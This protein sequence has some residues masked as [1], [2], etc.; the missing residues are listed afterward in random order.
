MPVRNILWFPDI[1]EDDIGIV[2]GKGLNL[3][4]MARADFPIPPGFVVTA[5]AYFDFLD[6]SSLRKKIVQAIDAIDTENTK[7]LEEVSE[8]A[9]DW[10]RQAKMPEELSNEIKKNYLK[11]SEKRIGFLSSSEECFVAV[12]SSATAEDLPEASF[13]GQQETYLNVHGK[14]NV[15]VA[16]QKCWASLF[17][18]RAVYYRKKQNFPTDKVGIAVVIQKMVESTASG[19]MFTADPTGDES[20]IIIEAGFGLG[21]A[22]VSGSVIPDNYVIDKK[23]MAISEKKINFQEWKIIKKGSENIKQDIPQSE[24]RKQKLDDRTILTLAQIGLEIQNYY[25]KPQDIEFAINGKELYIVQS[26]AITTLGLKTKMEGAKERREKMQQ[27]KAKIVLTGLGASPGIISGRVR[28]V[29]DVEDSAK[30]QPG[31]ILVTK[32][33]SPDWVPTMKKSIAIITDE[34][35]KTC[36]AGKTKVLTS[37][38]IIDFEE[39]FN[40]AEQGESFFALSVNRETLKSEWKKINACMKRKAE[41]IKIAVSQTGKANE[42]CVELTPSHKMMHL[43]NRQIVEKE[44]KGILDAEELVCTIDSIPIVSDASENNLKKAYL[45][46]ALFT[47]GSIQLTKR[48]GHITFVQKATPEKKEF[49]ETVLGHFRDLFGTSMNQKERT[50]TSTIRGYTFTSTAMAYNCYQKAPA[51][52]LLESYEAL[53]EWVLRT[54]EENLLMFLAGVIDGDGSFSKSHG[55]RLHI[56][57]SDEKLTKSIVLGCLRLGI[58]PTLQKNRETCLN[59]QIVEGLEKLLKY[60]KRVKFSPR[61][62][63][64]GVKL[65]SAKQLLGDIVNEVNWGGKI[66]PYVEKNLLIDSKKVFERIVPMAKKEAQ[67]ELQKICSSPIRMKRAVH[68]QN[69]GETDVFNIEVDEHHNYVVFTEQFTPLWVANCHAAIVSRELGIPCVVGTEKATKIL[70]D[71]DLVTVDGFDGFIYEGKVELEAPKNLEEQM[72]IIEKNE[73]EPFEKAIKKELKETAKQH[74][75]KERPAAFEKE[76]KIFEI[77]EEEEKETAQ[78]F[79]EKIIEEERKEAEEIVKDFGKEEAEEMPAEKLEEEEEKIVE[80]LEKVSVKV[81]VNVALPEAAASAAKT[82]A[83]GVGLLRAEHMITAAGKHPA[84]YLREGKQEELTAVVKEGVK[85]VALLFKGKPVL[86]RTFDARTDEF[87]HLEG[88][89]KEPEEDN[90]MIGWHGI[91]RDLDEPELLKA[92][93]FAIKQLLMEGVDNLGIMLPFV[94]NVDEVKQAKKIAEECGLSPRNDVKFGV[95]V[96]TPAA[97]WIIDDLI[98]EGIDFVSFGTNDLTQ[99]TLGLDRNNGK[100]QKWF[101]ELH[102]A[103]LK[104][105][106]HVIQACKQAHVHTGICGQAGSNPE[107]VRHLVHFGIDSVSANIDAVEKIRKVVLVE[108]KKMFMEK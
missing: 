38:G 28:V 34:G 29:P 18:A 55:C 70:E 107:M 64:Q 6:K 69:C 106:N 78:E 50:Y 41:T 20:K 108:E 80:L 22:I 4:L 51:Q 86:Y 43:Q 59:I 98:E 37:K 57:S 95:M 45:M 5:Q 10:I 81:N 15:V 73:I 101:S 77:E 1:A 35:G 72:P 44:I 91:R 61:E 89:D 27:S 60:T 74:G 100:V 67:T 105:V 71:N 96:E 76:K 94:Q 58:Q 87:R 39:V 68:L 12:R 97:C 99:L 83:D 33:T 7:Q 103:I 13:A 17:T 23:E 56:Y 3:G 92:Q 14:N 62:K 11:L 19:I 47:D 2:G 21:E 79:R 16:V 36:F 84:E 90:P 40:R 102:P 32:M 46:G 88:G 104:S 63:S 8:K 48:H 49:V 9:R 53:E 25:G 75:Q 82:N 30:V 31:D 26:R 93:F 42:N 85:K 52:N 24:A 66:K 54:D 65:F